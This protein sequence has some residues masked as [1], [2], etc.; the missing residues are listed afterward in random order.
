MGYYYPQQYRTQPRY[1]IKVE[2]YRQLGIALLLGTMTV[3]V[4]VYLSVPT[5]LYWMGTIGEML[6]IGILFFGM[7]FGTQFSENTAAILL[8]SFAICSSVTLSLIVY[9][10]LFLEPAIVAGAVGSTTIVV[11]AAYL[12]SGS[13]I[14]KI[15][16]LM[17]IVT[18]LVIFFLIFALLGFFLFS[19]DPM[20]FFI[21]SVFGAI[22]FSIYIFIDFARLENRM[23]SSPS[24]MALWLFY[25]I[26]YFLRQILM[27]L[28]Y[29]FGGSRD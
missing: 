11:L 7:L 5:A 1:D 26:V 18:I 22:I 13:T 10:G 25:D 15:G 2:A 24:L 3:A 12:Y 19:S 23:F 21:F 8:Y 29:M 14:N 17:K 16:S 9:I 27:V 28:I 6:I 4:M 20:F